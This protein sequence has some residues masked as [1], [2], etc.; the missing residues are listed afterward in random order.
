MR[1]NFDSPQNKQILFSLLSLFLFISIFSYGQTK[2]LIFE[3]AQGT[4]AAV[5]DP[6]GDGFVSATTAGFIN[7]DLAE[8]EIPYVAFV[9]PG[10]EPTSDVNNG[11]NCGFSDF[12]DS[13]SEDP[14]L[15]YVDAN[16]NWLF[17][18]RMGSVRPNAKS[19]SV[20][21][22][23][24]GLFGA[25][26]PNA[27]PDY[28]AANPGFE[29]EIV[30]ATKFGVFVYDVDGGVNC[31]PVISYPDGTNTNYQKSIAHSEICNPVNY[32]LDFFIDFDDIESYFGIDEDTAIRM[33]I[34]DNM[35]STASTVCQPS[36]ASDI[37]GVGDDCGS[38]AAC[39]EE[40][41]DNQG[42]CT[43]AQ[44]NAG[45]CNE[46]T[47]C[48]PIT[49]NLFSGAT[50]VSGSSSEADGTVIEVFVN[51]V[52]AGTTTVTGNS[53][54]V[55]PITALAPGDEVHV[56]ADAVGKTVSNY[57]CNT[58]I[59][60]AICSAP[61]T[62]AYHCGKSIIGNAVGGAIIKVYFGNS[63]TPLTPSAGTDILTNPGEITA[64]TTPVNLG[65]TGVGTNNFLWKCAGSGAST[66]C[67][68][69][70][71]PCLTNGAYRITATEPGKCESDPVWICVNANPGMVGQTITPAI[72]TSPIDVST[73]SISGTVDA[74]YSGDQVEIAL[75][76]D[77]IEIG[78]TTITSGVNW[79]ISGLNLSACEDITAVAVNTGDGLC[80]SDPTTAVTVS[81]GSSL[82]PEISGT[83][84]TSSTIS[85]VSGTSAEDVGSTITVYENGILEGTT[86]V[87]AGG[88]WTITGI[89]IAP[90]STITATATGA[91][92]TE[93]AASTG[94]LVQS[95]NP[96]TPTITT[97]SIIEGDSTL[98]G[99]GTSGETISLYVDGFSTGITTIVSSGTWTLTGIPSYVFYT[100][101]VVTVTALAASGCESAHSNSVTVDCDPPDLNL[102][103][104]PNSTTVCSGST[105]TVQVVGSESGIIY[106]LFDGGS[107]S[108]TSV[109]GTGGTFLW[110]V[111]R[112]LQRLHF[113]YRHL[114]SQLV[115]ATVC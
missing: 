95:Q 43:L 58:A 82:I 40:I 46:Y 106:Q 83:Y 41:V 45:E 76:A 15:S 6:N 114:K 79:T 115:L 17:R 69:S 51:S 108:G 85:E 39:Y 107:A 49:G 87:V 54:T 36:S 99:T 73:T 55:D 57:D 86:S 21:I 94:V 9:F 53:W 112:F 104:N 96:N 11:P 61:P 16:N 3:P 59:V 111:G 93:S 75:Y 10:M 30:L 100:D 42:P 4:G 65:G 34:V 105:A 28:H 27:D 91:C 52:S 68:A 24:D 62:S 22:D 103:V 63:T 2:G 32:F 60:D 25:T 23:T 14:A 110:L 47:E 37:G 19:Y 64:S 74:S 35:S 97:S 72:T 71:A 12:V 31:S 13:G 7:N 44:I 38:L 33:A 18:F 70:G 113:L 88:T 78:S 90:G 67:N 66:S 80:P 81:G 20:L 101:G 89:S 48:P 84:C 56:T 92:K 1:S 26:G 77:G 8:S 5:L 29:I 98:S 102:T 109:L 50:S